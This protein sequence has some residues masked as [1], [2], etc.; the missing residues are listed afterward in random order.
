[1]YS[2][3]HYGKMYGDS[4]IKLY[5]NSVLDSEARKNCSVTYRKISTDQVV[6]FKKSILIFI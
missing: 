5:E 3:D 4:K 2:P 6:A 1:M